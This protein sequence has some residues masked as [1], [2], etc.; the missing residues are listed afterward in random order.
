MKHKIFK[1]R[2]IIMPASFLLALLCLAPAVL[3]QPQPATV[4]ISGTVYDD[5]G[6][7]L[8]GVSIFVKNKI[9]LGTATDNNGKFSFRT[10]VES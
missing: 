7:P 9:S 1:L 6:L 8:P 4:T 10:Q 3:A 5:S 2:S